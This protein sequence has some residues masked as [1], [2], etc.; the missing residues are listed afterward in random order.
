ML[1]VGTI[2]GFLADNMSGAPRGKAAG[3]GGATKG[4]R[5]QA[6]AEDDDVAAS[7]AAAAVVTDVQPA[8]NKTCGRCKTRDDVNVYTMTSGDDCKKKNKRRA[9]V[10]LLL[11]RLCI[12]A[13]HVSEYMTTGVMPCSATHSQD[14][15][16]SALHAQS[17]TRR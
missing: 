14:G 11:A 7:P 4:K 16:K 15:R 13:S 5:S 12:V 3:A 2:Q 9:A 10:L 17:S 6:T 8:P 1:R